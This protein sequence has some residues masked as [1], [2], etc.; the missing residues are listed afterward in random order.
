M[1]SN[2]RFGYNILCELPLLILVKNDNKADNSYGHVLK[3]TGIFG[4]VQVLNI[5]VG[6]VRTKAVALLLGPAGMGPAADVLRFEGEL[7]ALRGPLPP[8]RADGG[9]RG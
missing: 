7:L 1:R 6:L 9:R 4:G 2:D 5:L 3:Y 8:S